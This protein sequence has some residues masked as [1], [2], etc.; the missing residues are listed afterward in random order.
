MAARDAIYDAGELLT[1]VLRKIAVAVY[2]A[3]ELVHVLEEGSVYEIALQAQV[4]SPL[5]VYEPVEVFSAAAVE[6]EP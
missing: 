3:R 4:A 5:V 6:R 1:A 2:H